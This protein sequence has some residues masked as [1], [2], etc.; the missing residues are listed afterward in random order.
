VKKLS[1]LEKYTEILFEAGKGTGL[2]ESVEKRQYVHV[3]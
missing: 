2:E 3:S 1:I